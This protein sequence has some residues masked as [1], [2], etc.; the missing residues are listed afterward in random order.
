MLSIAGDDEVRFDMYPNPVSTLLTIYTEKEAS[1]T[2]KNL[3]GQ[4]ILTGHLQVGDNSID[5]SALAVG[6][7]FI[8]TRIEGSRFIDKIWVK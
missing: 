1:Y 6:L 3:A 4:I 2:F 5:V 7:Y 8:H